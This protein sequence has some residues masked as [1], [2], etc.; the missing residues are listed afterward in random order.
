M[1]FPAVLAV[2]LAASSCPSGS[3]TPFQAREDLELAIS[4]VETAMPE[5]YWRQTRQDWERHKARARAEAARAR[6]DEEL[7]RVLRPLLGGIGEGHL[8]VARTDAMNCR[9]REDGRLFPLDLLWRDDGVFVTAGHGA[10]SDIPVG[11]RLLAINGEEQR[12]LLDEMMRAS[13]HDGDIR[14]GVMRDRAGRGYA[15]IRWWMRG[16]EPTFDVRLRLPDGRA[17]R[18][19]LEPI[20]VAARPALPPDPDPVATLQW[21]DADIAYLYVPTF[22][23]RRYRAAGADYRATLQAIFDEF[24][25]RGA[26]NLILDL[27]DN[28]GGSEPN[29]S[30]LF[31]YLVSA[32]MQKYASVHSRPNTLRVTSLSGKVFEHEIYDADELPTVRPGPSGDLFRLNAPPEGLMTHWQ[33]VAPVFTGRLVVLAG[34]Y[35]FSGGAELAS[36]LR[37]TN[38]GLFVGEEVGGT[39]GGNTSGYKWDLTLPHSGMEI[40]IPLLAFRFVWPEQPAHHGAMPHCFAQPAVGER[41]VEQDA[42]YRIAVAALGKPWTTPSA[43]DCPR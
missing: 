21:I 23:N 4:A 19:R 35:T 26:R 30:I 25:T 11:T 33:P 2:Q 5:L 34:G 24:H 41:R 16:N 39:H 43:A 29:E 9:Y 7:F 13:A 14:T 15:V 28:G 38:R 22:S 31:S 37:A 10:A 3:L 18:R 40:G 42:A 6:S 32:P 27:R 20:A 12:A 36:M 1:F 17:V 8:S